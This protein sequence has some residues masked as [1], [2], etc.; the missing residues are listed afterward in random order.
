M[1]KCAIS[2]ALL[3]AF[4]APLLAGS[5]ATNP[6]TGETAPVPSEYYKATEYYVVRDPSTKQCS[7]SS[8]RPTSATT[9]VVVGNTSYKTWEEA[10]AAVTTVCK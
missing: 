9:T 2:A 1:V 10:Q 5:P 6:L 8:A 7:V 3:I 4:T